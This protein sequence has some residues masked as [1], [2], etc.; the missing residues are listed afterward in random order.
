MTSRRAPS[1]RVRLANALLLWALLWGLG[2]ALAVGYAA[3][4][5]VDELLDESLQSTAVMMASA[6]RRCDQII[7][8]SHI[9]D[10]GAQAQRRAH[11]GS[12]SGPS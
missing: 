4:V 1:I 12:L 6:L 8:L 9:S 3:H 7:A 2:V 10:C 11:R 5:E